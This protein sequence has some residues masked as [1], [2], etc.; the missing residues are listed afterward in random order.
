MTSR[1]VTPHG[2]GPRSASLCGVRGGGRGSPPG[3]SLGPPRRRYRARPRARWGPSVR[4]RCRVPGLPR[5]SAGC[6]GDRGVLV[7]VGG[8]GGGSG[9]PPFGGVSI[10]SLGPVTAGDGGRGD[11]RRLPG[12]RGVTR[13]PP[14]APSLLLCG[15]P[16]VR[17][18]TALTRLCRCPCPKEPFPRGLGTLG[19]T[20]PPVLCLCVLGSPSP[21]SQP[22]VPCPYVLGSPSGTEVPL[23]VPTAPGFRVVSP[24]VPVLWSYPHCISVLRPLFV[25]CWC[26]HP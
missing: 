23:P 17:G 13:C 15:C 12:P 25:R 24:R 8:G 7:G 21:L 26:P 19:T 14:P 3:S 4:R 9:M 16:R 5:G 22:S 11:S 6:G 18:G 2:D 20:C 10:S 1:A